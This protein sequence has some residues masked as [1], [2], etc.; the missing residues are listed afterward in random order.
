MKTLSVY[1]SNNN[2][3]EITIFDS[4]SYD[5][6]SKKKTLRYVHNYNNNVIN[7]NNIINTINRTTNTI[8]IVT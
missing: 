8:E 3:I 4:K 1:Y 7:L 5:T 6:K 2:I